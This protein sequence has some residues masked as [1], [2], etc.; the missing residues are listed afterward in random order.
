LFYGNLGINGSLKIKKSNKDWLVSGSITNSKKSGIMVNIPSSASTAARHSS[1][2]FIN[3]EE[4]AEE[5]KTSAQ[6]KKQDVQKEFTFPLKIDISI[7]LDPGL[8]MGAVFN[9]A[10]GD[11]AEVTGN[12]SMKFVY[13][14]KQS[15]MSL[16][17]GY[18]IASGKATLS[19]K[20]VTKKT[21]TVQEGGKLTF[22]GDPL[23][24][25]FDLTALYNLRTDLTTLDPSL[26]DIGLSAKVP[27]TCSL[28]AVGNM[29]KMELK[30]DI[31]L[32]NEP[33]DVQR[34]VKSLLYTDDLKIKEIAYLLALGSFMPLTSNDSKPSGDSF[35]TS[36]ASSSITNQLNNLL[37]GVLNENWSIGT[38]LRTSDT[39]FSD[40]DMDVNISTQLF[41]NRL[42]VNSTLGYHN[43]PSQTDNFTGDFDIEYKLIPSG[44][45]LL[46]VYNETNNQYYEKAKT[47]QGIGIVYKREAKTFKRLFDKF[48]RKK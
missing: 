23:A 2:T 34:K 26:Q 41:N 19:L 45:V 22:K 5:A 47:T 12:G 35:W 28:T 9:Q 17:G 39:G 32:P 30:Y 18:E 4:A 8:T 44:N 21:F 29:D 15:D 37:S 33:D 46:K 31:L 14:L 20:N 6:R 13:D 11:M 24:T 3:T 43:D 10:T 25:A 38:D 40:V 42:T 7:G 1:I 27:V 48:R 16:Y 36:L